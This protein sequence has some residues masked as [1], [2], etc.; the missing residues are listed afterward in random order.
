[1]T[2]LRL[3]AGILALT[4]LAGCSAL[5]STEDITHFA[6][7]QGGE[8]RHSVEDFKDQAQDTDRAKGQVVDLPWIAGRPQ[9]LARDVTLPPALRAHV[10]TTLLFEGGAVGLTTLAERIQAATGILTQVAPDALLPRDDFL[11]RL[12]GQQPLSSTVSAEPTS[13]DVLVP[14][15]VPTPASSR[16]SGPTLPAG[17][18]RVKMEPLPP[19]QAPLASILDAIALRLGIYWRYDDKVG[20]IRFYR[21][22]TRTFYVRALGLTS[23]SSLELGLTGSGSSNSSSGQFATQSR[24]K[25]SADGKEK[26][27]DGVLAKISQFLTRSGVVKAGDGAASSIVVTDTKDALDHVAAFLDQENR[28]MSRRVRLVFEEITV[29]R[30]HVSQAGIDWHLIYN[31]LGRANAA[32][33]TGVA[34]QLDSSKAAGSVGATVGSGP[35][36]GTGLLM[37]A[38]SQIGTVV[39]HTTIPI[40]ARNR[41]PATYATSETFSYV[42]DLQQTQSTSDTSAPTVTV[43]QDEKTVGTFLTVVPDAQDDGRVLLTI[44][45]NDTRLIGGLQKQEFGSPDNPSFIQQTDIGGQG[46]VQE[47]ELQPGQPVVIGGYAQSAGNSTRRRLDDRAPIALGGSDSTEKKDLLTVLAVSAIPEEGF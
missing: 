35:F 6:D 36:A 5:R 26:P 31:S 13:A 21:T 9:P 34:T 7:T 41:R 14:A 27:I 23:E 32:T 1:M 15:L 22:Q 43:T 11:P 17:A 4:A 30:D 3:V 39:R 20:A 10:N 47:V 45:Y 46:V 24:S 25:F 16:V 33:A 18:A 40:L 28:I 42:K 2:A 38:L 12:G 44:S 19:G 37:S 8:G 29:Q